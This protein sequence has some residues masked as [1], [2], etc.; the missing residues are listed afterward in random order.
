MDVAEFDAWRQAYDSMSYE[1]QKAFYARVGLEHPRQA[2]FTLDAWKIFLM[3][4]LQSL[5]P[6]LVGQDKCLKTKGPQPLRVLEFGGWNGELAEALWDYFNPERWW[7]LEIRESAVETA[8]CHR[9]GYVVFI[10]PDFAW[11]VALPPAEVVVASHFAEHVRFAELLALLKNLPAK[12]THFGIE[13]PIREDAVGV[14]W[15]GYHGSHILEVGWVQLEA[16]F[17]ERGWK[18]YHVHGNL[19][20][21]RRMT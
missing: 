1:N 17:E 21:F 19:R 12:A 5:G 18:R 4:C 9:E 3:G 8:V 20:G 2:G 7:N 14:S 10:P 15:M 16:A 11:E 13:A 6:V